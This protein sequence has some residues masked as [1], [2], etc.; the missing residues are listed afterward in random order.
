MCNKSLQIDLFEEVRDV[1][2]LVGN[3]YNIVSQKL[4]CEQAAYKI[5]F[6]S[7]VCNLPKPE[8]QKIMKKHKFAGQKRLFA[9]KC[10]QYQCSK[11]LQPLQK[12]RFTEKCATINGDLD[13]MKKQSSSETKKNK[14]KSMDLSEK[15][16]YLEKKEKYRCMDQVK[17]ERV[18]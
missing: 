7:C 3:I 6:L 8:R 12:K 1:N 15:K 17:K 10:G 16:A 9:D 2:P 18:L 11:N 5:K 4:K 13:P 14:Y